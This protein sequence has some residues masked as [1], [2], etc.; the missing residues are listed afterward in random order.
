MKRICPITYEWVEGERPF[1]FSS[2]G[3]KILSSHLTQLNPLDYTQQA[4]RTLATVQADSVGFSGSQTKLAMGLQVQ[5]S[6]FVPDSER[7]RY[8]IK[9]QSL[10]SEKTPENESITLHLA[11]ITGLETAATGLIDALEDSFVL[12]TRRVDCVGQKTRLKLQRFQSFFSDNDS[13]TT[14]DLVELINHQTSFPVKEK[15]VFFRT[16][17]FNFLTGNSGMHAGKWHLLTDARN[18]TFIA[19]LFG[20]RNTHLSNENCG[21]ESSLPIAGDGSRL[22]KKTIHQYLGRELLE[23][24]DS[25]LKRIEEEMMRHSIAWK[26]AIDRSYLNPHQKF[27]YQQILTER[28][29]RMR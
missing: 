22:D 7:G 18:L 4:L 13:P 24:P 26:L 25:F 20:L 17:L 21:L 14:E 11:S 12:W 29:G 9:T 15:A 2:R 5:K 23:L 10:N 8:L 27:D 16:F 6:R 3:L 1:L 19:P 28:M